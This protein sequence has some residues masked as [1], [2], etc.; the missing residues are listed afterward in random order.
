MV[1]GL[2]G[3]DLGIG[4]AHDL[5]GLDILA[6]IGAG[7]FH[8]VAAQVEDAAPTCLFE[9]PEPV[10][11]GPRVGFAGF[12]PQDAAQRP[13][14][15]AFVRFEEFGG[16]DQVFEVSVED[17]CFFHGFQH[18]FGFGAVTAERF[19]GHDCLFVLTAEQDCFFVFVVGEGDADDVHVGVCDGRLQVGGPVGAVVVFS[20][21]P[22]AFL[23]ARIHA[24]DFVFAAISL[25][26]IRIETSDKPGTEHGYF[27][28]YFFKLL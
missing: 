6:D 21:F 9:V 1:F 23:P 4:P 26:G 11:V 3:F 16:I 25:Q 2:D 22:G 27:H 19:G 10:G 12:C 5:D 24:D 17:T 8:A 15:H 13:V 28:K 20:E 18:A 14:F 7:D